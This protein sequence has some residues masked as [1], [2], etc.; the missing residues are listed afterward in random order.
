MPHLSPHLSHHSAR[1]SL[2]ASASAI[3][4]L[5]ASAVSTVGVSVATA[6]TTGYDPAIGTGVLLTTTMDQ[7]VGVKATFNP[8]DSR[9]IG[10][11]ALKQLR[12]DMW[13]RN[14]AYID[15]PEEQVHLHYNHST[16][17]VERIDWTTTLQDAA[18]SVGIT[19]KEQ[20]LD[21]TSDADMVAIATQRALEEATISTEIGHNRPYNQTCLDNPP[22]EGYFA[23]AAGYCANIFTAD[24]NGHESNAENLAWSSDQSLLFEGWT[25]MPEEYKEN[26]NTDLMTKYGL[27]DNDYVGLRGSVLAGWGYGEYQALIDF[28]GAPKYVDQN[29]QSGHLWSLLNPSLTHFGFAYLNVPTSD[30]YKFVGASA[31]NHGENPVVDTLPDGEITRTLYRS[32]YMDE[33]PTGV[34]PLTVREGKTI[35][36]TH[37]AADWG[38]TNATTEWE[39]PAVDEDTLQW[40]EISGTYLDGTTTTEKLPI[41]VKNQQSDIYNPTYSQKETIREGKEIVLARLEKMAL[42][43]DTTVTVSDGATANANGMVTWVAGE[44]AE[45]STHTLTVTFD[46]PD[47]S[48]DVVKINVMV[49]NK[50]SDTYSPANVDEGTTIREGLSTTV[51]LAGVLEGLPEGTRLSVPATGA[52]GASLTANTLTYTGQPVDADTE[53]NVPVTVNYPD[54]STDTVTVAVTVKDQLADQFSPDFPQDTATTTVDESANGT[55]APTVP[56][57]D[58]PEGTT[59][60]IDPDVADSLPEVSIDPATGELTVN[61]GELNGSR[62]LTVPVVYT[63]PDESTTTVNVAITLNDL[64]PP[65]TG[66]SSEGEGSSNSST[67]ENGE[68]TGGA[69]AGI[70]IA[71]LALLGILGFGAQA[72][73]IL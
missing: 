57:T 53:V 40:A 17:T 4:L 62:T 69:I 47:E 13:D 58:L 41:L 29:H 7:T 71:V 22:T 64:T 30:P 10:I 2:L 25:N 9:T 14:P 54:G 73:G 8:A 42:P 72:A 55:I 27:T 61:A 35:T 19:T 44:V 38:G 63:Y 68:L 43:E 45:D 36:L 39:A 60:A 66:G 70:V 65:A 56:L 16:N 49:L 6:Q 11:P 48:Q 26:I 51:N 24:I 50:M 37:T 46:Y 21:V 18:K 12:A 1:S 33:A 23:N 32:T 3:A 5:A 59:V 34:E 15:N 20:Y 31:A 28:D 67:D 52:T